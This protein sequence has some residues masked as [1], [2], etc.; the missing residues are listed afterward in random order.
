V[1]VWTDM[2]GLTP[3]PGPKFLKKY[4]DLRTVLGEAAQA[5]ADEVREGRYP[6][7]EHG[8]T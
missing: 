2:A 4:A 8:Y 3:G 6:G 5:Y 7:P 1:L